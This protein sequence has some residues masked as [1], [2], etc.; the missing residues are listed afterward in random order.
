[1]NVTVTPHPFAWVLIGFN[2]CMKIGKIMLV[3]FRIIEGAFNIIAGILL[4]VPIVA[5]L[6]LYNGNIKL[7]NDFLQQ[8]MDKV[9]RMIDPDI[10]PDV[11][12][13]GLNNLKRSNQTTSQGRSALDFAPPNNADHD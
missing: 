12:Q 6:L 8:N 11:I 13:K 9:F 7:P 4:L 10:S 3:P 5:M 1:M 2:Y